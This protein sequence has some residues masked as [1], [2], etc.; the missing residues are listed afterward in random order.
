MTLGQA[1]LSVV[2]LIG[3]IIT[4]IGVS[5]AFLAASFIGSAG[6]FQASEEARALASSGAYD[7]L[8][9]LSRA[10]GLAGTSTVPI[11]GNTVNVRVTQDSPASGL[12]TITAS[13]TIARR[14]RSVK[15]IVS[16]NATS[17]EITPFLWEAQ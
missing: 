15:V 11:D 9:R 12:V 5:M 8:L 10:K 6:G 13:S 3:G 2:I 7:A 14:E 17:G 1:V 4:L 16:R